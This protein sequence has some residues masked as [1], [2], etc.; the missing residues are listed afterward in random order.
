MEKHHL[1]FLIALVLLFV[2]LSPL[3]GYSSFQ[4]FL[5]ANGRLSGVDY[6]RIKQDTRKYIRVTFEIGNQYFKGMLSKGYRLEDQEADSII[7]SV[8]VEYGLNEAALII[9][10]TRI[11]QAKAIDPA[12]KPQFWIELIGQFLGAGDALTWNDLRTGKISGTQFFMEQFKSKVI[13]EVA[14]D[15]AAAVVAGP[16]TKFVIDA[17]QNCGEPLAKE[18][19]KAVKNDEIKQKA[20]ASAAVLNAFY[21]RCNQK[22]KAA[23]E[24]KDTTR[25][26]LTASGKTQEIRTFFGAQVVQNWTFSCDLKIQDDTESP[27]GIYSGVM[28]VDI[29]HDMTKFDRKYLWDVVGKLPILSQIHEKC[30]WQS[31]YDCWKLSSKLEKQL[32]AQNVIVVIPDNVEKTPQ[33]SMI[34]SIVISSFFK[35]R[36]EFWSLHPIWLVP[37]KATVPTM[38]EN[39][40]YTLPNAEGQMGAVVYLTGEFGEDKLSPQIYAMSSTMELWFET[41]APN[42]HNSI[43]LS[44][45]SG[46]GGVLGVNHDIFRDLQSGIIF[47]SMGWREN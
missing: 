36:E 25:W 45:M 27:G 38:D 15:L 43:D 20:I 35:S 40:R 13:S 28:S 41:N 16:A 5:R 1:R 6:T 44:Q 4:D 23:A 32:F 7:R 12:F 19:L 37:D 34:D 8:M 22:L 17:I 39:G 18:A 21:A 46:G 29:S 9:H 42:Y 31:F 24:K 26:H 33:N 47:L 30:P 3:L 2:L 14:E 10:E 11:A